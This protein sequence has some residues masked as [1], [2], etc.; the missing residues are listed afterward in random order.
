MPSQS[1]GKL[2]KERQTESN[3]QKDEGQQR[4]SFGFWGPEHVEG[5]SER[6]MEQVSGVYL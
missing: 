3:S 5:L 6:R 4:R 1:P 2:S